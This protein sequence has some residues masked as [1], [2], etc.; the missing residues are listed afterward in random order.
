[1]TVV[2]LAACMP[3]AQAE[4]RISVKEAWARPTAATGP[5]VVYLT[6]TNEGGTDDRLIG[7]E[8]EVA[9]TVELHETTMQGDRMKMRPLPKGVV[10]PAGRRVELKPGGYHLMLIGLRHALK[11]GD[12]FSLVLRFEQSDPLTVEVV[13]RQP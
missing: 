10:I 4:P 5:G 11:V 9:Q 13:V 7:A 1:M 6:L 8:T 2:T 12:H 3:A